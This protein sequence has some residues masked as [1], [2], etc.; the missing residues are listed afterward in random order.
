MI[1]RPNAQVTASLKVLLVQPDDPQ[2]RRMAAMVA[3]AGMRVEAAG[4]LKAGLELL[5]SAKVPFD[6]AVLSLKEGA[7]GAVERLLAADPG[8]YLVSSDAPNGEAARAGYRA[9][10]DTLLGDVEQLP[11]V[12]L[13]SIPAAGPTAAPAA[14]NRAAEQGGCRAA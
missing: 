14:C 13:A 10:A 9:G 11:R 12:L 7:A 3:G 6:F 5:R 1:R 2:R 4:S 8:T